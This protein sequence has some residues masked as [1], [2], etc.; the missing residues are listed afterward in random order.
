[1][2]NAADTAV[3]REPR[4]SLVDVADYRSAIRQAFRVLRSGG[5]FI[6][7]NLAPMVTAGNMWVKYGD[8]T[9]LHF[10][11][12]N[13]LDEGPRDGEPVLV[14]PRSASSSGGGAGGPRRVS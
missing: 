9:K 12:D 10:R 8:G 2:S 13:Y 14:I 3:A 6:V 4:P 5:R 7:C 1:M 11:L